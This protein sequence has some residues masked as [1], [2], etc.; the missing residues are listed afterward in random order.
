MTERTNG[1]GACGNHCAGCQDFLVLMEDSDPLRR[2]VAANLTAELG[3]EVLSAEVGC[4]GCWGS[5]HSSLVASLHCKI[6]QCVDARGFATCADCTEFPCLMY[7][8]QFPENSQYVKNI[9]AIQKTGL[10]EWI[11]QQVD[12]E[13]P[14]MAG[15]KSV[16]LAERSRS[17]SKK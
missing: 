17:V 5:I 8:E 14:D 12:G 7:L 15:A 11:S 13:G 4:E 3:R 9:R 2:Q 10:D 6:R 1:V 16:P